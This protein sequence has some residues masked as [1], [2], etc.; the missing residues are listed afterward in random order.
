M[1]CRLPRS[2][3]RELAVGA[4]LSG[5]SMVGAGFIST[6]QM[7]TG[8]HRETCL[9]SHGWENGQRRAV[10]TGS[11]ASCCQPYEA[12]PDPGCCSLPELGGGGSSG[13]T[14]SPSLLSPNSPLSSHLC[15]CSSF[16]L[17]GGSLWATELASLLWGMKCH[18][19]PNSSPYPSG[20]P[21]SC[22]TYTEAPGVRVGG[23]QLA[24]S[25]MP[26]SFPST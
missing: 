8:R 5:T 14:Q 15:P 20:N 7:R 19:A 18:S 24:F 22:W 13:G 17:P 3:T 10:E 6:A 2:L 12:L 16:S 26:T 9:R 25:S 1:G 21:T 11:G 23:W 4:C